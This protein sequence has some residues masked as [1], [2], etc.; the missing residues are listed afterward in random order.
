MIA[1]IEFEA[2]YGARPGQVI[3]DNQ[4]VPGAKAETA[5]DCFRQF[6]QGLEVVRSEA[7]F[8]APSR[9]SR[10]PDN[11]IGDESNNFADACQKGEVGYLYVDTPLATDRTPVMAAPLYDTRGDFDIKEYDGKAVVLFNDGSVEAIDI[12]P[13]TKRILIMSEGKRVD[14]FST[15]N[16]DFPAQAKIKYPEPR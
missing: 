1:F 4:K 7:I 11:D 16:S 5:N 15:Q 9:I 13:D 6:L 14:L 2:E 3:A 12:N 8:Y 10:K